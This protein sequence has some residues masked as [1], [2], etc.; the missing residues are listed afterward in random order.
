MAQFSRF[1]TSGFTA[2]IGVALIAF[3][4]LNKQL[5]QFNTTL[6]DLDTGPGAKGEWA[7][8]IAENTRNAAVETA[9]FNERLREAAEAQDTLSKST[10]DLIAAQK[11]QAANGKEVSD[12]QKALELA[13]LELMEKLGQLTPEQAVRIRLE[14]DDAAF[15]RQL[16]AEKAATPYPLGG[17]LTRN[18][19]SI[20]LFEVTDWKAAVVTLRAELEASKIL[21]LS[22][23]GWYDDSEQICRACYPKGSQE[24][25]RP[26]VN[27]FQKWAK[28]LKPP[29]TV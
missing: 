2:A 27:R 11:R 14:I 8:K 5:D 4:Y 15:K 19:E 22:Q 3:E 13:R 16:E 6:D 9:V 25:F 29:G 7:G 12:A 20:G 28:E 26:I 17:V 10:D 18:R 23:I 1:L 21:H 24:D